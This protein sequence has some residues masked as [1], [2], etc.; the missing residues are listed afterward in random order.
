M[1]DAQVQAAIQARVPG[2]QSSYEKQIAGLRKELAEARSDPD[3]YEA[4]S[5]QRLEAELAAVRQE[6][7]ALRVARQYPEVFPTYEA[8]LSAKSPVEQL[9][10]LQ[11]FVQGRTPEPA[12]GQ[13]SPPPQAPAAPPAAPPPVD[14]NRNVQQQGGTP[15]SVDPEG[16]D[17]G[18]ADRII[19]GVGS[20]WPKFS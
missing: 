7:E 6:A 11:A 4:S 14:P 18:L 9:D 20:V 2:L 17:Q 12:Q 3:R 10:V 5:S 15:F 8:I 13:Q 19:D 16:M 1:V